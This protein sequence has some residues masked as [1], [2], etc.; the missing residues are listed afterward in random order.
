MKILE[1]HAIAQTLIA[2]KWSIVE[3][4]VS[5]RDAAEVLVIHITILN[6]ISNLIMA[7]H[8]L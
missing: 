5:S 7:G 4:A 6:H 3:I 2:L 8:S 1:A